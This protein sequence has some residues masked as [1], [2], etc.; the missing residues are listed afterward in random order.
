[1]FQTGQI[2]LFCDPEDGDANWLSKTPASS[3]PDHLERQPPLIA[4]PYPYFAPQLSGMHTK[5]MVCHHHQKPHG[6]IAPMSGAAG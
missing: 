3:V 4:R 1:M 2:D 5:T 6:R